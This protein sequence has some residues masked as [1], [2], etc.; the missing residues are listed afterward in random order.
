MRL[1]ELLQDLDHIE[2]V[3]SP[4]RV[5]SAVHHDSRQVGPNDIFVAIQGQH[6]DGRR[7][8]QNLEAAVVIAD[9]PVLT[10]EGV[11][12]IHVPCAR[13][14]LAQTA[15]SLSGHP[16]RRLPVV[17]ITGTNGKP[18]YLGCWNQWP[19]RLESPLQFWGRLDIALRANTGLRP[20]PPRKHPLFSKY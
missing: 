16:A 15:A 12:V 14:A 2:L 17:E 18:L 11:A 13:R 7:F 1:H 5:V 19:L 10:R 8:A 3:G 4:D 6:I 20:T 9:G